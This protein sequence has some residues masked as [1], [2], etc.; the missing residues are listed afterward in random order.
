MVKNPYVIKK[1]APHVKRKP[2]F[3][4]PPKPDADEVSVAALL[5][6]ARMP[7]DQEIPL[8]QRL[9]SRLLSFGPA[10]IMTVS[11]CLQS[12][13]FPS[14]RTTGIVVA[15]QVGVCFLLR[16]PLVRAPRRSLL[17]RRST[18]SFPEWMERKDVLRVTVDP[19]LVPAVAVGTKVTVVG[20]VED[21]RTLRARIVRPV[22]P[23]TN[24]RLWQV[25][26]QKR[27]RKLAKAAET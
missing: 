3:P 18:P 22:P 16:D 6:P 12:H 7:A 4:E 8:W 9:P 27:R 20:E 21:R 25:A 5:Q 10:E 17:Q 23:Q 11:E 26:L 24:L 15:Q 13:S 2:L 19:K 1:A 14:V